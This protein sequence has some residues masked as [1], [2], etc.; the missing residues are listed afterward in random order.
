MTTRGAWLGAAAILGVAYLIF[1]TDKPS[2]REQPAPRTPPLPPPPPPPPSAGTWLPVLRGGIVTADLVAQWDTSI[3]S[4]GTVAMYN[5]RGLPDYY[6]ADWQSW[7]W[8]T[9]AGRL[10]VPNSALGVDVEPR[11]AVNAQS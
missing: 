4:P 9:P 1:A 6:D 3:A 11:E 10:F 7:M 2:A 5:A 8:L